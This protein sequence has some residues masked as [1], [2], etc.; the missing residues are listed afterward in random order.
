MEPTTNKWGTEKLKN[1]Y[2]QSIG[3]QS[4]ESMES[5]RKKK[6]KATVRRI[7]RKGCFK[8]RN[9]RVKE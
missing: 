5:A 4:G 6:R 3:K 2:V 8:A 1:G 7:G 9:K